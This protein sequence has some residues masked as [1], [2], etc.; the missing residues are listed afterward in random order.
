MADT[1]EL[2]IPPPTREVLNALKK[3]FGGVSDVVAFT[4]ALGLANVA[5]DI[6]GEDGKVNLTRTGENNTSTTIDLSK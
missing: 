4:R 3:R 5:M 6:A 1:I 2:Q